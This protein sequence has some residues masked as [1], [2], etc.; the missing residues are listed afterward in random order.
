MPHPL[1]H[2]LVFHWMD[3]FERFSYLLAVAV[4][5]RHH[6][7]KQPREG[8]GLFQF[9]GSESIT[10]GDQGRS[11]RRVLETETRVAQVSG[12][13]W[14]A[15]SLTRSHTTKAAAEQGLPVAEG[16]FG[17]RGTYCGSSLD[18]GGSFPLGITDV[19]SECSCWCLHLLYSWVT[20]IG[21]F[22][23]CATDGH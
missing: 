23:L 22:E 6:D 18:H 2:W 11:S 8:K 20:E 12:E 19:L 10:E 13:Q 15:H 17:A 9:T 5:D 4:C 7:Q 14:T 16:G 3:V 21:S 1:Y